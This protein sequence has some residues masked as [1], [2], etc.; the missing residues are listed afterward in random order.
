MDKH[1]FMNG[2]AKSIEGSS[3]TSS[4]SVTDIKSDSRQRRLL[5]LIFVGMAVLQIG[6]VAR[7]PLWVDEVFSLAIA[8][9]HSLELPSTLADPGKGDFVESD[10]PL[11]AEEF[12]SYLQHD[13]PPESPLRV[14]RAV[15]LSDTNPPFYYLLLYLWTLIFGTTDT[16]LRLFSVSCSLASFPLLVY[17][18][19]RAIGA[20]AA[21][22]A[23]I[24]FAISPL[25]LYFATEG[26]M[27][28]FLLFCVF[29]IASISLSLHQNGGGVARHL[30]WIVISAL[31]FLTH[32]F[33]LFPW[34]A[35]VAFLWI[36]P[37]KFERTRILLCGL[38]VGLVILPWYVL[39]IPYFSY[40]RVTQGWLNL[41]PERYEQLSA[42]RHQFMQFFS[43]TGSGLWQDTRWSYRLS[44]VIFAGLAV[45]MAWRLR[46]HLF[47]SRLLLLWLW[48]VIPCAAPTII[49]LGQHTYISNNPRYVL[50]ALPAAYLLAAVALV[51]LN[52]RVRL[53]TVA[54]IAIAW[55]APIF[56][57]YRQDARNGEPYLMIAK[58]VSSS[59]SQNDL[60]LVH[61]IPSGVLGVARYVAKTSTMASWVQQ[62]GNRSVPG[63]LTKLV[64]GRMRIV[65]VSLHRLGEPAPEEEWLRAH[66]TIVEQKRKGFV[67]VID[68]RP[69]GSTTF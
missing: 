39:A 40:W 1:G 49:D 11:V 6:L 31:G 46:L 51:Y 29:A 37:G 21:I 38:G 5:L 8:T 41:Q 59:N 4:G 48:F 64:A 14:I 23:C 44:E 17:V 10:T 42:T 20:A 18:A 32:Y 33:F 28:S 26:R 57:I 68:F 55:A 34:A 67:D 61:S 43:A 27:Y 58:T 7:Q 66:G 13:H 12:R 25:T 50:T 36:H 2:A 54:L 60:V 63:S 56:N 3:V 53:L 22:P 35:I 52:R 47:K 30:S 9:G 16:A 15:L 69:K 62:L 45:Y 24:L 19:R 65:F